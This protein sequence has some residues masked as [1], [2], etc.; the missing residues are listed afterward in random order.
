MI[1]SSAEP[2]AALF[3]AVL[4]LAMFAWGGSWV[5]AKWTA[6]YSPLVTGWW[7]FVFTAISFAA[8]LLVRGESFHLPKRTWGFVG[9]SAVAIVLYNGLFLVGL[10]SGGGGYGGV[11]VPTTSPPMAFLIAIVFLR[12]RVRVVTALGFVLGLGGGAL[13]ILGPAFTVDAFV[14]A[15]NLAFLGASLSYAVLVHA[16]A[17]VQ[18]DLSVFR[19][20]FW[21]FA[22]S[23]IAVWPFAGL[24]APFAFETLRADFWVNV[25]YL[26]L[27]SG[28]FATTVYFVAARRLGPSRASS[29]SFLVPVAA[30]VLA[31]VFLGE[32]PAWTSVVG[33]ALS[34]VAIVLIQRRAERQPGSR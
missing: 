21:L 18:R 1:R 20:S 6:A 30:V 3:Y 16:G 26:T 32:E 23:S 29:F 9:L 25:L 28:T 7:R 27:V 2:R 10:R 19:Y 24:G 8:I 22:L 34:V 17:V 14:R 11:L 31:F 13:Q 12:E 4:A 33:G 5:T 15:E